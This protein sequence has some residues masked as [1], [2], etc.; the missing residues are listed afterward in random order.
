MQTKVTSKLTEGKMIFLRSSLHETEEAP[1]H[2]PNKSQNL[3]L[4][5]PGSRSTYTHRISHQF[6]CMVGRMIPE[7]KL[8][9]D[10]YFAGR[11]VLNCMFGLLAAFAIISYTGYT[12]FQV[13][14]N[15]SPDYL[16]RSSVVQKYMPLKDANKL[17]ITPRYFPLWNHA[18]PCVI[19][20][21]PGSVSE[22]LIYVKLPKCAS[23]TVAEI[24]RYISKKYGEQMLEDQSRCKEHSTHA[25][26]FELPGIMQRKPDKSFL[27]TFVRE[28]TERFV[29]DFFYH[30]VSKR[31]E[32][33]SLQ[34]FTSYN[35]IRM[36]KFK[37]LGGY[38]FP[39]L[40]TDNNLTKYS[41][42]NPNQPTVI[43]NH[44]LLKDKVEEVLQDFNFI[45]I[46]GSRLDESLVVLSILLKIS[47]KDM[48][49]LHNRRESG[50]YSHGRV[51]NRCFKILKRNTTEAMQEYLRSKKWKAKIF[52]DELLY[53][54][55]N[56]SLDKTIEVIGRGLVEMRLRE[57]KD[58]KNR[59]DIAC[60]DADC[61]LCSNIGG[62]RDDLFT[63][64]NPKCHLSY[65]IKS[66]EQRLASDKQ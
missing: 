21:N 4:F 16:N 30:R 8:K 14:Y 64:Q 25:P 19:D 15:G 10:H 56:D 12:F 11:K 49:Y 59:M 54:A 60:G 31:N 24:V 66:V 1:C 50:G 63:K 45:G 47:F 58:F 38:Q 43:Q 7:T 13:H 36:R 62:L 33:I 28:P 6:F 61:G 34:H 46:S 29:S 41:F 48:L 65:C 42:W 3:A 32:S 55:A 37:G 18:F 57:Y 51:E 17:S 39:Y 27:F 23:T 44:L 9:C 22:G 52:G 20:E 40:L 2:T 5:I 35:E 53:R 26:T